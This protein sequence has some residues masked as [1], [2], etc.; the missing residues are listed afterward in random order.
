MNHKLGKNQVHPPEEKQR[1]NLLI[2]RSSAGSGKTFTLVLNYLAIVLTSDNPFKFKEILAITFT[3]KA[4]NEMKSR[5]FEHLIDLSGGT[6]N[7]NLIKVYSDALSLSPEKIVGTATSRLGV[8]LHNYN[9]VAIMTID[10][11]AHR[12][13]RSFSRDLDLESDFEIEMDFQKVLREA[14]DLLI[15]QVGD[16]EDLTKLLV[17]YAKDKAKS[18]KSWKAVTDLSEF[19]ELLRKEDT[20]DWIKGIESLSVEELFQIHT[21]AAQQVEKLTDEIAT[22]AKKVVDHIVSNNLFDLVPHKSSGWIG[23]FVKAAKKDLKKMLGNLP[24]RL[25]NAIES[26]IWLNK[27]ATENELSAMASISGNIPSMVNQIQSDLI[28]IEKYQIIREQI[29]GLGLLKEIELII[30]Q[31]KENNNLVLISDFN[32]TISDIV[33]EQPTPFIYERIGSKFKHY[34]IDEFQDTSVQQWQNFIPLVDDSLSQGQVNLL[35]GDAKQAIYRFRNGEARQFV[36]LPAIFQKNRSPILQDAERTFKYQAET[37][38]LDFNYRSSKTIVEFNND[39]FGF[40][41]SKM[42]VAIQENYQGYLQ[43]PVKSETGLVRIRLNNLEQ[44]GT[45]EERRSFRNESTLESVKECLNDGFPLSDIT[46]LVRKNSHGQE[47]ADFL[48]EKGI[49]VTSPD[50]LHILSNTKVLVVL[51]LMK[52]LENV[53]NQEDVLRSLVYLF[54]DNVTVNSLA[55]DLRSSNDH[56]KANLINLIESKYKVRIDEWQGLSLFNKAKQIVSHFFSFEEQDQFVESFIENV[57]QFSSVRGEDTNLFF[58]WITEKDPSIDAAENENAVRVMSIHKSKGLEFPVVILHKCDWKLKPSE[59][60]RI[61]TAVENNSH[62]LNVRLYPKKERFDILGKTEEYEEAY[63]TEYLDGINLFYVALTRPV[64]RLYISAASIPGDSV[65]LLV[66]DF[67]AEKGFTEFPLSWKLGQNTPPVDRK[68]QP[69]ADNFSYSL[70]DNPIVEIATRKHFN[71]NETMLEQRWGQLVHAALEQITAPSEVDDLIEALLVQGKISASQA[72]Q[73]HEELKNTLNHP[74]LKEW[75]NSGY[76]EFREKEIIDDL[77]EIYRP[78]RIII[79]DDQT[80]LLDFKTGQPRAA[81][82]HQ[83]TDYGHLLR[84][85]GYANI[86]K[87]LFYVR[88]SEL[89]EVN[90]L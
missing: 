53:H 56:G 59:H 49:A 75:L 78:D 76:P 46:I 13:I 37:K 51:A 6:A 67:L 18:D 87:Y 60:S 39:L 69:A 40:C 55:L 27:S 61:W 33:L 74:K 47:I 10:R 20:S 19:G 48:L 58:E 24:K 30:E 82:E 35:V 44:R 71:E 1:G 62:S 38:S 41:L 73:M 43:Q 72:Q 29:V 63:A 32:K 88:N 14:I 45:T 80:I 83:I 89:K 5:V 17:H 31:Y 15:D 16:R 36:M 54:P 23:Y 68:E 12:L 84:D 86:K 22:R 7:S 50:S 11:F 25:I 4:A 77:G 57:H 26:D 79:V 42:P 81:D 85:L 21:D 2:Y 9:D 3:N 52:I 90:T 28:A 66:A 34:F 65:A 70:H 64:H 8:M